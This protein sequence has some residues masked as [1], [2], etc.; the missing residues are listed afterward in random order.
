[1]KVLIVE[2]GIEK[3]LELQKYMEQEFQAYVDCVKNEREAKDKLIN[4]ASYDLVLLDMTLPDMIHNGDL[5]SFGGINVLSAMEADDIIIPVIII[6][7]Y[8]DFKKM[9]AR[10]MK[11]SYWERNKFFQKEI[12]YENIEMVENFD[13]LDGRHKYMSYTYNRVYY[14]SVEFSFYND[15][16]KEILK[17]LMEELSNEYIGVRG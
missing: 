8:W 9:L 5:D 13:Y 3:S 1:M 11:D 12:A 14:A 7:S 4:S 6:T 10:E 2:D 15:R 16:W 17:N